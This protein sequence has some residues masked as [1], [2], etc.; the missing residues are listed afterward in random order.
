MLY[1]CT[2]LK[3][4]LAMMTLLQKLAHKERDFATYSCNLF[5]LTR[6]N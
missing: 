6:L 2:P 5:E 3:H 4:L 1:F